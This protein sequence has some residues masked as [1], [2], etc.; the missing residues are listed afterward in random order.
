MGE[1]AISD[2]G[3]STLRKFINA[4]DLALVDFS[5]HS[6]ARKAEDTIE[7]SYCDLYLLNKC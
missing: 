2:K 6:G 7:V 4:S 1:M 5:Y 3:V